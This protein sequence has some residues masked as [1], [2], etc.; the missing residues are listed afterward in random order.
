MKCIVKINKFDLIIFKKKRI[1]TKDW[2][3]NQNDN[4]STM[5][6]IIPHRSHDLV[7]Q[8][9]HFLKAII[10]FVQVQLDHS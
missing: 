1:E 8:N 6:I 3:Q 10:I 9:N 2:Y 4:K 5:M 7:E